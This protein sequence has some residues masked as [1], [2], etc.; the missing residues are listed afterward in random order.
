MTDTN[1]TIPPIVM[2]LRDLAFGRRLPLDAAD[3]IENQAIRITELDVALAAKANL[4]DAFEVLRKHVDILDAFLKEARDKLADSVA[5]R[6]ALIRALTQRDV[7]SGSTDY[8]G[9]LV[10]RARQS[11]VKASIKYPQPNYTALKIAE[12]SG[13]VVRGCVHYAEGRME[14]TEV[15]GEIV[16]LMAMLY[17]LVTE[18]D[19][20]N[21]VIPPA[22]LGRADGLETADAA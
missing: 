13:E 19:R 8:F 15:E 4:A 10:S 14:W 16:Q 2:G 5:E 21:G 12:E 3:L 7:S 20:V 1:T 9:S 17:R 18:G 22:N 6:D 11:A